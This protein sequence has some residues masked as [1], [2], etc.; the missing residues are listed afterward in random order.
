MISFTLIVLKDPNLL[1]SIN[2]YTSQKISWPA[3]LKVKEYD[4]AWFS[5]KVHTDKNIEGIIKAYPVK[6]CNWEELKETLNKVQSSHALVVKEGNIVDVDLFPDFI[7]NTIGTDDI[8]DY[9]L[10]G[11]ILDK[12]ERYYNLHNQMFLI[13]VDHWKQ[14][15]SPTFDRAKNIELQNVNRSTDNFHDDYTPTSITKGEGKHTYT[16]NTAQGSQVIS[17]LLENNYKVRPFQE[18]ERHK[19][20]CCYDNIDNQVSTIFNFLDKPTTQSHNIVYIN[21]TSA[22]P[23]EFTNNNDTIIS[24]ASPVTLLS[25]IKNKYKNISKIIFYDISL[26]ALIWTELFFKNIKNYDYEVEKL[27]ELY[28]S[29]GG[30]KFVLD[31]H[32][33]FEHYKYNVKEYSTLLEHLSTCDIQYRYGDITRPS[34]YNKENVGNSNS[35]GVNF[36]N[37]W[38]YQRNILRKDDFVWFRDEYIPVIEK[39]YKFEYLD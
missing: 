24:V 4:S 39:K 12:K 28:R 16:N 18:Q 34:I 5:S 29:Y 7:F 22:R 14:V 10:I 6:E 9:S 32:L 17:A 38:D 25:R 1:Q 19:K 8:V 21:S 27:F 13:N 37:V 31:A 26:P 36:T 30:E 33:E 15:G 11:H 2:D 3:E 23:K 20:T 35:I